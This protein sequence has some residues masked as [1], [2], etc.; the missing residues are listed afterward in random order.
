MKAAL[1]AENG[2]I[3]GL[4]LREIKVEIEEKD[5]IILPKTRQNTEAMYMERYAA[6]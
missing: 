3:Q 1:L 5:E 6:K 2:V 4:L